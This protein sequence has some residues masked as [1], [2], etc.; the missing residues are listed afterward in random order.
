V[1]N[2]G[3]KFNNSTHTGNIRKRLCLA[4]LMILLAS[5]VFVAQESVDP[6]SSDDCDVLTKKLI[7]SKDEINTGISC[8]GGTPEDLAVCLVAY[9][10]ILPVGSLI[11]S[12]SVVVV[13]N[14][15]NWIE[16]QGCD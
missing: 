14:A 12:G 5:C 7:L 16:T 3:K 2:V 6:N 8:R 9:G 10:V 1:N 11:V 13:G 15:L 4:V